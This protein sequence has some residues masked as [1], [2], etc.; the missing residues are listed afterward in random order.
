MS[1]DRFKAITVDDMTMPGGWSVND[2]QTFLYTRE[3]R[4]LMHQVRAFAQK[5]LLPHAAAA[6]RRVKQIK[7]EV[8]GK[9]RRE[10]LRDIAKRYLKQLGEGGMTGALYPVEYGG[11]ARGVTAE[12]I[13][14][15]ELAA[16]GHPGESIRGVS[17]TLGTISILRYGTAA[18]KERHIPARLRGD[19]LAALAI[20]EPQIGSDT[21]RMQT[22]A[23]L[24]GDR[25]VIN[26][27]KRFITGGG[28][29]DYLTLFAITDTGAH[30]HKG[31]STFIVP[32]DHS[33]VTVRRQI[34]EVTMGDMMDNAWIDFNDVDI[35]KENLL[36]PLNG[37]FHVLMDELDTERVTYCMGAL[38][39]A[40]RALEIAAE[41][42]TKRIQFKQPIAMFEGVS[43]KLAEM[44]ASLDAARQVV[45][46]TAK[47]VDAGVPAQRESAVTKLFV[48]EAVW[49]IVDHA[50]QVLGGIGYTTDFPVQAI[51]RSA[52]LLRIGAGSDE[53][54]KF[55]IAREVLK[56]MKG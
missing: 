56:E 10:R 41:Y 11:N 7:N 32:M 9:E 33:G 55:L 42:S 40:R 4:E 21:S 30:P 16:A 51:F 50:M 54:M 35:P 28:L 18:Q 22:S 48:A 31:M 12:C 27:Q 8:D 47:M 14:D 2:G 26:G 23:V 34:D 15:E 43:F 19:E 46:R 45:Y 5:E 37:G 49:R 17:L 13:V 20:T 36:G 25:W 29:A 6:H 53:I 24:K 44:Y 1:D 38:G 3:E 52:R 39:S